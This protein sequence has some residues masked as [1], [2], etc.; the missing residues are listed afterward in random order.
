M[1]TAN[2]E[3]KLFDLRNASEQEYAAMNT[4]ANRITRRATARRPAHPNR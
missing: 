4:F 1:T 3:I 2:L